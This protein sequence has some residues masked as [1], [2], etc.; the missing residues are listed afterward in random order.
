MRRRSPRARYP[1]PLG[2]RRLARSRTAVRW[3]RGAPSPPRRAEV[4][5][6]AGPPGLAAGRRGSPGVQAAQS[7]TPGGARAGA[8]GGTSVG[9]WRWRRMRAVASDASSTA[10]SRRRPPQRGHARTSNSKTRRIR[11]AQAPATARAGL[12]AG[13]RRLVGHRV[14]GRHR[15]VRHDFRSPRRPRR[16][17]AVIQQQIHARPGDEDGEA[18]EE[19]ARREGDVG[20]P[21]APGR[22]ELDGDVPAWHAVQALVGQRGSQRVATDALQAIPMPGG[23]ADARVEIEALPARV[24]GPRPGDR[25]R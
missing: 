11:S 17:H 4:H 14:G 22:A 1:S 21:I 6:S 15:C 23:H 12:R 9:R 20:G 24:T 13:R 25:R 19:R 18:R 10:M 2:Q 7:S 5:T 16:E 8:G 3:R